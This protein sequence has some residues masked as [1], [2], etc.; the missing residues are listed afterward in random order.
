[1]E[2]LLMLFTYTRQA[3]QAALAAGGKAQSQLPAL[4]TSAIPHIG[5]TVH[6]HD[7]GLRFY[8]VAREYVLDGAAWT[9]VIRLDLESGQP[10][11]RRTD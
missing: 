2:E 4:P 11:P 9:L 8:V 7:L 5:D 1:M 3:S 6:F 10:N